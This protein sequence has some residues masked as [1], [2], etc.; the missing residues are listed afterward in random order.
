MT[1]QDLKC[2]ACGFER[3]ESDRICLMCGIDF[4]IYQSSS[5]TGPAKKPEVESDEKKKVVPE[6][7]T[8]SGPKCPSC[9]FDRLENDRVCL[10]CGIDFQI[11]ENAL[12]KESDKEVLDEQENRKPESSDILSF[13]SFS[14]GDDRLV[15][16]FEETGHVIGFCLNCRSNRYFGEYECRNCG[17]VFAK[18]E[19]MKQEDLYET[20]VSS[21]ACNYLKEFSKVLA[22]IRGFAV[23]I[24]KYF[25]SFLFALTPVLKSLALTSYSVTWNFKKQILLFV[26]VVICFVAVYYSV[27]S[28]ID[29]YRVYRDEKKRIADETALEKK[30]D[31]FRKNAWSLKEHIISVADREGIEPAKS[32]LNKYD[33]P[34]LRY[35]PFLILIKSSL[36]E[37]ILNQ[38][39]KDMAFDDYEARYEA[40]S[41]LSDI[42]PGN[43]SY[44]DLLRLN[45]MMFASKMAEKA[46]S[47][48]RN[49]NKDKAVLEG[50]ITIA[51]KAYGLEPTPGNEWLVHKAKSEKLLFF[52]GNEYVVM[53]MRDDGFS[54]NKNRNQRKIRV[55]LKNVGPDAFRIN[56][57]FFSLDCEDGVKYQ[58][59]DFSKNLVTELA[60]GEEIEG[61]VFFY[62]KS[63]PRRIAFDHVKLGQIL[64]EFP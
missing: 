31:I 45:R 20:P 42:D 22:G 55:W 21:G 3:I 34:N 49:Y 50:A 56:P 1:G 43:E 4:Q 44:A 18:L 61:D 35:N 29:S 53:A 33:I 16:E 27:N 51:E 10:M 58:Y 23:V 17:A 62:T 12:I 15:M 30:A 7:K 57:D 19:S 59:N 6:V 48:L 8:F 64:R 36:D 39:I 13:D 54:G 28:G 25:I 47:I 32:E 41:R 14:D 60:P 52:E 5:D 46:E 24:A 26:S 9:G 2:P 40:Y 63:R 11:Y 37:K 38:K